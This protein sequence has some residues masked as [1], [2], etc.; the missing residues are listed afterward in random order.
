MCPIRQIIWAIKSIFVH[1][2]VFG[3]IC[4]CLSL[5]VYREKMVSQETALQVVLVSRYVLTSLVNTSQ[6]HTAL[7]SEDLCLFLQG[8]PGPRGD[9]GEPVSILSCLYWTDVLPTDFIFCFVFP[10]I[11]CSQEV[12]MPFLSDFN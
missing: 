11:G 4:N 5:I 6:V 9:P 12:F 7:C 8:Y 1:V 2:C 3:C 10:V